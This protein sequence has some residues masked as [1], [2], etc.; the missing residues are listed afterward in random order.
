MAQL[1]LSFS[2]SKPYFEKIAVHADDVQTD[3]ISEMKQI[4]NAI[5]I[6]NLNFQYGDHPILQ[7]LSLHFKKGG[8]YAITGPSGCG[9]STLLKLLL[10]WLPD[11]GGS[12]R[13]DGKDAKDFTPEQL[14]QQMSYIEQN[15]FLFNSTIRDNITLGETF[16]D[17]QMEKALHDSALVGDLASMPD[18]LD[19]IVGEE[20][21]SLS[22]GQKQRVAIAR[23]LIHNRSLLLVD[24]GTWCPLNSLYNPEHNKNG[25]TSIVKGLGRVNGK[26]CC[27]I[28]SDN[29]KHAG[30]WVPGQADNLLRGSD[31]AKR[32]R[33]PLI[34]L[35]EC[36]GVELDKQEKVYPNR[37]G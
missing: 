37:R 15:V 8:K 21:G 22:G 11:Y 1:L 9:K 34:Y 6:E 13:F 20:G 10:G 2:S 3:N 16:T 29:K 14:Q 32:L 7:N 24:E 18:G 23:A 31:T 33:I 25:S 5:T 17:E 30:T 35:L 4:S 19:T 12:I 26:W 28:A 27:I 36:A